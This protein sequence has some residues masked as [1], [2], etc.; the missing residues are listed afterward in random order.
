MKKPFENNV[1]RYDA[2][3]ERS[4][5]AYESELDAIRSLLPK[6]RNGLEIGV[7]TGRFA[8][9]LG[10]QT[11]VEPS[12][13]MGQR[14]V[15]RG[16]DVRRG[17]AENLPFDDG[18]F[19]FV[20]FV[21]VICFLDNVLI[22]FKEAHRIL[23]PG[24][25][26]VVGFIDRDSPLGRIYSNRKQNDEFYHAATFYSACEVAELLE[27]ANFINFTYRQTIFQ[28]PSALSSPDPLKSGYG[29]GSF[30]VVRGEKSPKSDNTTL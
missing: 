22:A 6:T 9:M 13:S 15:D 1:D 2:W 30:V 20:L 3:F 25:F 16:I 14:A 5:F 27:E 19:D 17:V 26:I 8:S 21:T 11:G 12:P 24:G 7:G 18:D 28:N 4:R 10:I 23:K 29:E